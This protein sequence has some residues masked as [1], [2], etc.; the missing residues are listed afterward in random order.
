LPQRL[1]EE[2]P[3]AEVVAHVLRTDLLE[4]IDA[5][6]QKL[7]AAQLEDECELILAFKELIDDGGAELHEI[8]AVALA[9]APLPTEPSR[10]T[11]AQLLAAALDP[12]ARIAGLTALLFTRPRTPDEWR[13]REVAQA[14]S[15][16]STA[17]ASLGSHPREV[18]RLVNRAVQA[19]T[20]VLRDD[21]AATFLAVP[22][23]SIQVQPAGNGRRSAPTANK[24]A[25]V[26]PGGGSSAADDPDAVPLLE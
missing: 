22:A 12:F 25:V 20:A 9:D 24:L 15:A 16:L 21:S 4:V 7:R 10:A 6:L 8:L 26:T 17:R 1:D 5:A 23:R 13:A 3:L 11:E 14:A 18:A 2:L 19:C